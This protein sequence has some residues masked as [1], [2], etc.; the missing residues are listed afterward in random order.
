[1]GV[2]FPEKHQRRWANNLLFDFDFINWPVIYK[3]NYYCSLE[4]KLP[5]SK[6]N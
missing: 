6:S 2:I 3:S 5:F 4:T 1:M